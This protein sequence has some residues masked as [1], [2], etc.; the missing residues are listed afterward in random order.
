MIEK[1]RARYYRS[2]LRGAG[3]KLQSL[4]FDVAIRGSEVSE[5]LGFLFHVSFLLIRA[6]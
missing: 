2:E 6:F 4:K 3:H 5:N 1:L